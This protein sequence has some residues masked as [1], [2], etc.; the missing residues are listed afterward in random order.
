MSVDASRLMGSVAILT[1][2]ELESL[3]AA[4]SAQVR[5]L[6]PPIPQ[7]PNQKHQIKKP[8]DHYDR[9]RGGS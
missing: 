7:S 5:P 9:R 3:W 1:G 6:I 4:R 8:F 2:R